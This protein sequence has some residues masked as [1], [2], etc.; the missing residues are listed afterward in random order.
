MREFFGEEINA[1]QSPDYGLLLENSEVRLTSLFGL[2]VKTIVIDP[3]HGGRDPGAIGGSG[4]MEKDLTLDIALRLRARLQKTGVHRVAMTRETDETISL[5]RRAQLANEEKAD[6]FISIHINS[7]P[8]KPLNVIETYYFGPSA[9]VETLRLAEKENQGSEYPLEAFKEILQKIGDTIK[10][11]E[12]ATF[13]RSIQRSLF[14]NIQKH[15]P[16]VH[17]VGAKIAPF[18]VLLGVDAPSVLAEI[19]CI[20]NDEQEAKLSTPEY[21]EKIASFLEQGIIHYLS[22]RQMHAQG[23]GHHEPKSGT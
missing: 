14:T 1:E 9:D 21:R 8:Q 19:S 22:R 23:E 16:D 5:S 12:S 2:A 7:L 13:A 20:T 17:D 15:D 6:L 4:N 10:H 18:V 3:G 11:Q